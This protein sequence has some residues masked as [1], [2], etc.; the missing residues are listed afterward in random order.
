VVVVA[1]W[2]TV[3]RVCVCVCVCVYVYDQGILVWV[4]RWEAGTGRKLTCEH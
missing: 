2:L 3:V 4:T 1:V